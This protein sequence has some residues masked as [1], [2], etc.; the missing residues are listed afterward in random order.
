MATIYY[1]MYNNGKMRG[2]DNDEKL[3]KNQEKCSLCGLLS[4]EHRRLDI[5]N[6]LSKIAALAVVLVLVV[7]CI[8]QSPESDLEPGLESASVADISAGLKGLPIDEFFEESYK[9]LLLRDPEY[10]T[11]LGI[12]ES[13]GVGNDQLTDISD[14][15]IRETYELHAAILLL[16]REY[17]R[18]QLT[19]EQQISYDVYEW[20]LD[21][22]VRG[23]EFMYYNYPVTHFITGVQNQLIQFFTDIHPV[24]NKKD[25]RD[26]ITRLQ[27]VD[28]KFEQLIEGLKLREKN[29]I[30]PPKFIIQWSLYDIRRISGGIAQY[31]PFY[32]VFEEKIDALDV[33]TEEKQ[34][35]LQDAEKAVSEAVIPAFQSLGDYLEHLESVAPADDGVWQFS[36]GEEYYAYTLQHHTTTR[37]TADEIHELGLEEVERIR[38]EMRSIFDELGYPEDESLSELFHRVATDGG[39]VSGSQVIETYEALIEEA[40]Q[41]LDAA[42]DIRPS[43]EVIVIG[44][45]TGGFY[46]PG[47]LDGSRPGAFYA[48]VS[49]SEYVYG[50][51]SLAYHEA[52]PGHHFQISLAQELD[53]PFFRGDILFTG[54]AEG[55]ALYAEQLVWEL[56]WYDDD[57]YGNLGRLQYEIFRAARLVVDTGIHAKGWT[58]DQALEYMEE[59]VGFD[60]SVLDL[61]FEISRY[62]AWPGQATAY[63]VGMLKI[64]ELRQKAMD[65][66]GDQFDLKE[67]HRVILGNGG[68]PLDI[69]EKV[70]Q[71][72]IDA[73]LGNSCTYYGSP[74]MF[75]PEISV[76][77]P[78]L[79]LEL[80]SSEITYVFSFFPFLSDVYVQM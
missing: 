70:V 4:F 66:L 27:Q 78:L 54:Y 8:G 76:T 24:T 71:D 68:M 28:T 56:G 50:M 33:S 41:N 7:G 38:L 69:L 14:A 40:D 18:S 19:R 37:M 51:P 42:F 32:T 52:I 22:V 57:P 39:R 48:N 21:D 45:P 2:D 46:V 5:M 9:Q 25:A 62:V 31:L 61:E 34:S 29:G 20:Y 80:Y 23:Q 59:N 79:S 15:Y 73:K 3:Y 67:F 11:E 12:A 13:Y 64:L 65:A 35:L 17:D 60:P 55:W 47:A 63:K 1:G 36:E 16:L 77:L 10:L 6:M 75:E 49:G 30:I 53:L 58:F 74:R 43:A 44:G 72:Y 26:Y